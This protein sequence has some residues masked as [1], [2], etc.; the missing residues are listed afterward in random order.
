MRTIIRGQG[1]KSPSSKREIS[2][3]SSVSLQVSASLNSTSDP[4]SPHTRYAAYLIFCVSKCALEMVNVK[5]ARECQH[6]KVFSHL[7]TLFSSQSH[8][9]TKASSSLLSAPGVVNTAKAHRKFY[10]HIHI[11]TLS[12]SPSSPTRSDGREAAS[13]LKISPTGQVPSILPSLSVSCSAPSTMPSQRIPQVPRSLCAL[14]SFI[15]PGMMLTHAR[16]D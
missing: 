9:K 14:P 6:H 15:H 12:H 13:F 7:L 3:K 1:Q 11:F 2:R 5:Y 8:S 10:I 4:N 16:L